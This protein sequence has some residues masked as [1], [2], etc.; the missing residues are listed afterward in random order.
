[1]RAV[2]LL[3]VLQNVY[4]DGV[5]RDLL[6]R[7]FTNESLQQYNI[8]YSFGHVLPDVKRKSNRTGRIQVKVS[9]QAKK[10]MIISG[11]S[12]ADAAYCLHQ[13]C[14]DNATSF[15]WNDVDKK[16]FPTIETTV[17]KKCSS[18]FPIQHA[19]NAVTVSYSMQ[20]FDWQRYVSDEFHTKRITYCTY[21]HST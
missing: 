7:L 13:L 1:M 9:K 21:Y 4:A 14:F 11:T 6:D 19:L 20:W 18:S 15:S 16:D 17:D 8:S 3:L 5:F 12:I 10:Q 2:K